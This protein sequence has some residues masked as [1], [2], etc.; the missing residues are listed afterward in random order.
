MSMVQKEIRDGHV[1][2]FDGTP[3]VAEAFVVLL[4][5]V[6][7]QWCIQQSSY[8]GM[9]RKVVRGW[10]IANFYAPCPHLIVCSA[11]GSLR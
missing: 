6:N 8:S 1:F 10:Y 9:S 5:Y 7:D 11:N 2:I 4:R 3:H